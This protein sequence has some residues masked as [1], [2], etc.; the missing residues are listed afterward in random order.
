MSVTLS[1][2]AGVGAQFLDNNGL[3]LSGGQIYTY[4]AGT[5]TPLATYT[6]N[7]GTIAQPNPIIL[8]ASG[9]IPVGELWLLNGY[10]YKFVVEDSNNVLI[11][12]YDNVPSSA[13][14]PITND[15][16]SIYYEEGNSTIAGLFVIGDTYLITSIGTT[17]FQLIGAASNTVGI[18]FIATGVGTGTGTAQLSRTVQSKLQESVSVKDFGAIGNGTTDDTVAF[19]N[20][21][22]YV[23]A[24]AGQFSGNQGSVFIPAGN[25]L[26]T[27]S[28]NCTSNSN[29]SGH[30]YTIYGDN[31]L[32]TQIK[33]KLTEAYPVFDCTGNTQIEISN[34]SITQKVDCLATVGLFFSYTVADTLGQGAKAYKLD[35]NMLTGI[36]LFNNGI[37]SIELY[38]VEASGTYGCISGTSYSNIL[39]ITSK[40]QTIFSNTGDMTYQTISN[41]VFTGGLPLLL[42]GCN[43]TYIHDTYCGITSST[44]TLYPR[45]C[46]SF[47]N[48][49]DITGL[50]HIYLVNVRTEDQTGISPVMSS[51]SVL[52]QGTVRTSTN[53][54]MLRMTNCSF[55]NNL[56]SGSSMFYSPSNSAFINIAGDV[57]SID[58]STLLNLNNTNSGYGSVVSIDLY[59]TNYTII[60]GTIAEK[61]KGKIKLQN[62]GNSFTTDSIAYLTNGTG[63]KYFTTGSESFQGVGLS[64][65]AFY[66]PVASISAT[67]TGTFYISSTFPS[68]T[69]GSGVQPY[70]IY[71]VPANI[72]TVS[73]RPTR[74]LALETWQQ[75]SAA[76]T[77]TATLVQGANTVTL[78]SFSFGGAVNA[79]LR[80]NLYLLGNQFQFLL[81][82]QQNGGNPYINLGGTNVI[83]PTS[84]YTLNL[85]V[86]SASNNPVATHSIS[87]FSWK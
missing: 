69:G 40:Y 22:D 10:G 78:G 85:N 4:N 87:N 77:V 49:N 25:Y 19:Q 54:T 64:D 65:T 75:V 71:S 46:I 47:D 7:L 72:N 5:T 39:S 80:I 28:L 8:N 6:T 35:I 29:S 52:K 15:A 61:I 81:E 67:Q 59:V 73:G 44:S 21:I 14:P 42:T 70:T 86:T 9:R 50:S 51:F 83:D 60:L 45:T 26:I 79:L 76:C 16:S 63:D 1:L 53:L 82:M 74:T 11:G 17:N 62:Y 48:S 34:F 37:D 57:N 30:G 32:N 84:A 58:G 33:S 66:P 55:N 18:H 41:C 13:Q 23:K 56:T 12:T 3:P 43:D 31:T 24:N 20:A 38:K 68:Y 27:K 2:F 36:G